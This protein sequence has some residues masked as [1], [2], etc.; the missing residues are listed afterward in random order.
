MIDGEGSLSP[1]NFK[2]LPPYEIT[3]VLNPPSRERKF[4]QDLLYD[5]CHLV[6]KTGPISSENVKVAE[7]QNGKFISI[8]VSLWLR[9]Q[10][11]SIEEFVTLNISLPSP[12]DNIWKARDD[13]D[14]PYKKIWD[15]DHLF[16]SLSHWCTYLR[17]DEDSLTEIQAN[18]LGDGTFDIAISITGVY[19]GQH[20]NNR[21]ASITMRIQSMLFKPKIDNIDGNIVIPQGEA[22]KTVKRKCKKADNI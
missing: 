7:N 15:G 19:F 2:L 8:P 12:L 10:L 1:E 20:L 11:D 22:N 6:L 18:E 5:G 4:K 9:T 17:Q 3:R 14:T 13:K 21:L 16:I